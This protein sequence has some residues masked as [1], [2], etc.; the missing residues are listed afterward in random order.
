MVLRR[1]ISFKNVTGSY[2]LSVA[3]CPRTHFNP[4]WIWS[5]PFYWIPGF[6]P[7]EEYEQF[8]Q[9]TA[10]PLIWLLG[11]LANNWYQTK[12]LKVIFK[13]NDSFII[14]YLP[15]CIPFSRQWWLCS[16]QPGSICWPVHLWWCYDDALLS[17]LLVR[18]GTFNN[19]HLSHY[20]ASYNLN[21]K[22]NQRLIKKAKLKSST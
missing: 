19:L 20:R 15:S 12:L 1:S 11:Y 17:Y 8:W 6:S 5:D 21:G 2:K 22:K 4:Q 3:F 16:H 10:D 13:M 14:R 7:D 18:S 9:I